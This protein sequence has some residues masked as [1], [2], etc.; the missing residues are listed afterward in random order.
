MDTYKTLFH[1]L[2]YEPICPNTKEI[3]KSGKVEECS[4][5]SKGVM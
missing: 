3:V 2:N 4:K 1:K 5:V